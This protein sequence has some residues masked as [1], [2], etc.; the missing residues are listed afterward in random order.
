MHFLRKKRFAK[1]QEA[2][3]TL[4]A[5]RVGHMPLPRKQR[6]AK[7]QEARPALAAARV[8]QL[9]IAHTKLHTQTTSRRLPGQLP[10]ASLSPG[11]E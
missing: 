5:A 7:K 3:P 2:R 6:F 9:R 11:D 8:G 1:K 4:A 10:I